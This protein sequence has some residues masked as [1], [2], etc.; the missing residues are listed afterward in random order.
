MP[1]GLTD[2]I[3][4]CE[5][6]GLS[7]EKIKPPLTANISLSPKLKQMNNSGIKVEF[8]GNCLK[9]DK[10]RNSKLFGTDPDKYSCS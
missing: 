10:V 6:E 1:A 5:S 8:K 4:E 9:Q 2:T 7:I 3:V